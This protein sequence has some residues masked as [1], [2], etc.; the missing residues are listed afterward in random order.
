MQ[1]YKISKNVA[2]R[3]NHLAHERGSRQT[4]RHAVAALT[5]PA[6]AHHCFAM[7]DA[8]QTLTF[9]G[10]V[11]E[12]RNPHAWLRVMFNDEKAGGAQ[13]NPEKTSRL[14]RGNGQADPRRA[15]LRDADALHGVADFR[16]WASCHH[17]LAK[18][19]MLDV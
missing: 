6:F 13:R 7:F 9:Q 2:G 1:R 8:E 18:S 16:K 15:A 19:L 10:T 4:D 5:A 17:G 3:P 11:N 14:L 12:W